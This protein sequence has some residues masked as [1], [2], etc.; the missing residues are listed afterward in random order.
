MDREA[1]EKEK[2]RPLPTL[3]DNDFMNDIC[4]LNLEESS[5]QRLLENLERDIAL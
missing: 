1:N 4:E 5:K 2:S 3:K